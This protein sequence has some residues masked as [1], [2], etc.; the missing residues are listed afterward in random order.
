M[1]GDCVVATPRL[2][3]YCR[4]WGE[5]DG[6]PLLLLHGSYGTSRWWEFFG[7][8]LP[9]QIYAVAPDLRGCGRSTKSDSGYRVEEQA[10]DISALIDALDWPELHLVAHSSSGPIA[11]EYALTHGGALSTL[12]LVDSAPV[13]GVFTPLDTYLL[14]EQMKSDRQLL[15]EAIQ[16]LMP[17]FA[18]DAA[19][20]RAFFEQLVD[21]AAQMA[22]A[23]FTE[24]A[25][26]LSSWNRFADA[27]QL[28]LP[29]LLVWGERDILVDRDATTRTLL[30]IPGASNLEVMRGIGHSPMLE[31]PAALAE[32]F[33]TFMIDDFA[34][35]REGE[36]RV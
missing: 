22:P 14:L 18:L 31:A 2:T 19:A 34:R 28:T 29:T 26:G 3:F 7:P 23:A 9:E 36:E 13:E 16:A 4:T 21:D 6:I 15:S 10:E 11:I 27:R 20:N 1:P 30:A 25:R 17:A 32:L 33:V 8:L 5:P 24:P 12:T 35:Y